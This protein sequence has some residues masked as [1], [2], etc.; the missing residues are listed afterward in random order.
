MSGIRLLPSAL[1]GTVQVPPSKSYAQRAF[2][3]AYLAGGGRVE[4]SGTSDDIQATVNAL[5]ALDNHEKTIDCGASAA[6]LRLLMPLA[7]ALGKNVTFTG[8]GRLPER[9]IGEYLRLFPQHGVS[10]TYHGRLPVTVNGRLRPGRFAVSGNI[11]SQY[12]SG[13]LMA[14]PLLDGDSEIVLTTPLN[15][16][17]Y[18][19]MTLQML[20]LHGIEIN[21]TPTGFAIPGRQCY[22]PCDVTVEG[23]WSQAAF[24]LAGGVLSGD[25][26]V[27]GL[28]PTSVQGDRAIT[29]ILRRFGGD[30]TAADNGVRAVKSRLHGI[31]VDVADIPDTLP[32]IAVV[33]ACA[34]GDTVITGAE[35]LKWKESDRI[36]AT[37]QNLQK[38]G[39][40]AQATSDALIITGGKPHGAE[41]SGCNDHRIVM[42]MSI[43]AL[44]ADGETQISDAQSVSKSYPAYFEDYRLLGGCA[45]VIDD[46]E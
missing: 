22:Q 20:H 12:I 6:T 3:A 30:I 21:A 2:I 9:P 43:L 19:T 36:S 45:H 10:C 11:S 42:A 13:L 35:R 16:E 29:K 46:R 7:A 1:R 38:A 25:V 8:S 23:D 18:V 5:N 17:P 40:A 41:L 27:T 39:I 31:T 15:S 28:N 14:L 37:V 33:A 34:E 24:F 32:A 4:L 44:A 26:T